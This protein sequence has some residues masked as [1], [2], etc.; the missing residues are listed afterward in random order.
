MTQHSTEASETPDRKRIEALTTQAAAVCPS[1]PHQVPPGE[2]F[3][4]DVVSVV[5]LWWLQSSYHSGDSQGA[6][7]LSLPLQ[8]LAAGFQSLLES[9]EQ[10]QFL[11]L[12]S[13][14]S[15]SKDGSHSKEAVKVQHHSAFGLGS[16]AH[17]RSF[18]SLSIAVILGLAEQSFQFFRVP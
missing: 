2:C 1:E 9:Q 12:M 17:A 13:K 14:L 8:N 18:R 5:S 7:Y 3:A 10:L 16:E 4:I 11:M 15:C 6:A